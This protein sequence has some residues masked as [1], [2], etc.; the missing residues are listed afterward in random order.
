MRKLTK[1]VVIVVGLFF[2]IVPGPSN[3]LRAHGADLVSA[4][5]AVGYLVTLNPV[6][7]TIG[8]ALAI[9]AGGA[10]LLFQSSHRSNHHR[11]EAKKSGEWSLAKADIGGPCICGCGCFR[12]TCKCGCSCV[13]GKGKIEKERKTNTIEKSEFFN[14]PRIKSNYEHLRE[15]VYRLKPNGTPVVENAKFLHWD[16]QHKDVE[17]YNEGEKHLGSLDPKTLKLYKPPVFPR[18]F[19]VK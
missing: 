14:N 16:K 1:L 4:S 8:A 2:I 18:R 11:A 7:A 12:P 15:G 17:V 10:F 13:C 6:V 3:T 9:G 19:P 5:F